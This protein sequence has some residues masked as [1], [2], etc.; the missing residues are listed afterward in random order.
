MAVYKWLL[1]GHNDSRHVYN[2]G[3]S[4][5]PN[6]S[7]VETKIKVKVGI[8]LWKQFT[9]KSLENVSSQVSHFEWINIFFPNYH[10]LVIYD[11][12]TVCRAKPC[13][14][15]CM[16]TLI[17]CSIK[18]VSLIIQSHPLM[19]HKRVK[20]R[21]LTDTIGTAGGRSGAMMHLVNQLELQL[22]AALAGRKKNR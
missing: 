7:G 21:A 9:L 14:A 5:N 18:H 19:L 12:A 4:P 2:A 11:N 6:N 13:G 20:S 8:F 10:N 15:L 22:V 16:C 17:S 3:S 1:H